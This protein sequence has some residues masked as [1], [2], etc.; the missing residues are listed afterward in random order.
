M[1]LCELLGPSSQVIEVIFLEEIQIIVI[2]IILV[3]IVCI[4]VQNLAEFTA[5]H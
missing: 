4:D 2:E 5:R 1:E 3:Y